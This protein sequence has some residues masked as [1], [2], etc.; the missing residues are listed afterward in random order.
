MYKLTSLSKIKS[1]Q[2]KKTK[3][4]KKKLIKSG[5]QQVPRVV[6]IR[7][8]GDGDMHFLGGMT[9]LSLMHLCC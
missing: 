4:D 1:S 3:T 8:R 6:D 9:R 7:A 2:K 5:T